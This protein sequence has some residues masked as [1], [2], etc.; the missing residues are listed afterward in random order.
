MIFIIIIIT[1]TVI[2]VNDSIDAVS[3]GKFY[4]VW[5]PLV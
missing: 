1:F 4:L 5:L 3:I 2:I